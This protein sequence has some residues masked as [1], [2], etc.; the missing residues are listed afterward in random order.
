MDVDG[1]NNDDTKNNNNKPNGKEDENDQ[2]AKIA[3][4]IEELTTAEDEL[5]TAQQML[6]KAEIEQT[7]HEIESELLLQQDSTSNSTTLSSVGLEDL[8]EAVEQ[9]LGDYLQKWQRT[10]DLCSDAIVRLQEELEEGG[11]QLAQYYKFRREEE[12]L[13]CDDND[14]DGS[15]YVRKAEM[16]LGKFR[17]LGGSVCVALGYFCATVITY[18]WYC[19]LR[20]ICILLCID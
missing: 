18:H 5:A 7:R 17:G 16:A 14:D 20:I 4:L 12:G 13:D 19:A 1:G 2:D 3:R 8:T 11:V 9:E 6:S 10:F 15:D